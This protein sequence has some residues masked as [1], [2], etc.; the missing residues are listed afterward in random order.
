MSFMILNTVWIQNENVNVRNIYT[1]FIFIYTI[2]NISF[3]FQIIIN[4]YMRDFKRR[5]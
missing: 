3:L 4:F 1:L 5:T 2:W